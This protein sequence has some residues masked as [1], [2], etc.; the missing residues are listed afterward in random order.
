MTWKETAE[1]VATAAM[2]PFLTD[3]TYTHDPSGTPVIVSV[4]GIF[5]ADTE[6]AS[7][8]AAGVE[9]FARR[10]MVDVRISLLAA[11]PKQGDG[12]EVDGVSYVVEDVVVDDPRVVASMVLHEV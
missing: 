12:V 7:V 8:D 11:E 2:A 6:V 3:V 9:F 1:R 4:Q 10:P 5:D